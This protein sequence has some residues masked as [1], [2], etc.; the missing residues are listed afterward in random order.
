MGDCLVT[1]SSDGMGLDSNVALKAVL[2][3]PPVLLAVSC[4]GVQPFGANFSGQ[5]I[6]LP[7]SFECP[8]NIVMRIKISA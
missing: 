6:F 1:P 4:I 5:V 8:E 3:L 2:N 7:I